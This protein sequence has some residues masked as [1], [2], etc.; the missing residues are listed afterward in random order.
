MPW[1]VANSFVL[2]VEEPFSPL[3]EQA[4]E[5]AA[6][7][8]EGTYRKSCWRDAAFDLPGG[9]ALR[10]PA[11]AHVTAVANIVQ[12][13]G[14]GEVAVAAA[15]LHDTL[16]DPNRW[17]GYLPAEALRQTVG[18]EVTG[19][20]L[21]VTEQKFD[22]GGHARTWRERKEGYLAGLRAAPA[23]ALA[24]SL[25]DKLH[26]LWTMNRALESGIDIFTPAADRRG[27]SAGPADQRWFFEAVLEVSRIQTDPR[28]D[29]L[30]AALLREMEEFVR[31]SGLS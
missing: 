26:N 27:L 20:V 9:E 29:S 18:E 6:Q 19:L 12:R 22:E 2:P 15:F 14:W 5:L 10:V 11:M 8:H 25:A 24:I 28:F 1:N 13:C 21:A 16:E 31:L 4:I 17:G 23:A 3:V 30:R 7:W